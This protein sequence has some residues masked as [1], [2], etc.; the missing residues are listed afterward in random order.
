MGARTTE[1]P[2]IAPNSLIHLDIYWTQRIIPSLRFYYH[3]KWKTTKTGF[4]GEFFIGVHNIL[5]NIKD[6]QVILLNTCPGVSDCNGYKIHWMCLMLTTLHRNEHVRVF[7]FATM[8]RAERY[9]CWHP[10]FIWGWVAL[11]RIVKG[12]NVD[13]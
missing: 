4:V 12:G 6:F 5:Y 10:S 7:Q 9:P 8:S 13:S 2:C 3:Y 11:D 1:I